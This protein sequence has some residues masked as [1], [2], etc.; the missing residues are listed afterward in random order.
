MICTSVGRRAVSDLEWGSGS[1]GRYIDYFVF[2]EARRRHILT[3]R[4]LPE[5]FRQVA[6]LLLMQHRLAGRIL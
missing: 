4:L 5:S 1:S 3:S 2:N 6:L